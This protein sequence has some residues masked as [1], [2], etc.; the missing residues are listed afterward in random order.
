MIQ[1]LFKQMFA[2]K[3]IFLAA[4]ILLFAASFAATAIQLRGV[5]DSTCF[6]DAFPAVS[7]N[8]RYAIYPIGIF[9]IIAL[10]K[11]EFSISNVL[12][13]KNQLNLWVY[14]VLKTGLI[15][16]YLSIATFISVSIVGLIIGNS[17]C[18][19]NDPASF[20]VYFTNLY[21]GNINITM[22][23]ITFFLCILSGM[24][25]VGMVC[26][27]SYWFFNNYIVGAIIAL[28]LCIGG[29]GLQINYNSKRGITYDMIY[30]GIDPRYQYIYPLL[31][32]VVLAAFG[33]LKQKR[34]FLAKAGES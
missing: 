26:L 24:Y 9:I 10:L 14:L 32:V 13:R 22:L 15:S 1:Q 34:E 17:F 12:R 25:V 27:I 8:M 21:F 7:A 2:E 18:N 6:M 20:C 29:T 30:Q 3:R 16:I 4:A 31:L 19:W 23:L 11:D 28:A 5:S 33:L